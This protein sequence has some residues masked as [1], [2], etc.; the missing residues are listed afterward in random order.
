MEIIRSDVDL[1]R[2]VVGLEDSVIG[3]NNKVGKK[4]K[5][6]FKMIGVGEANDREESGKDKEVID[7]I[8]ELT[9]V[10]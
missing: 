9:L 3:G 5:D 6:E 2:M 4:L 7:A 10:D 8:S 1:S